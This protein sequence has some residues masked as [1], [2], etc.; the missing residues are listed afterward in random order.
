MS[1][2][3]YIKFPEIHHGGFPCYVIPKYILESGYCS[4]ISDGCVEIGNITGNLVTMCQHV[5]VSE[6]ESLYD[7]IWC[8]D[9]HGYTTQDLLRMYR[10]AY[11][12][13]LQHNEMLSE[14]D[15]DNGWGT[16]SSLHTF[17]GHSIE[18]LKLFDGFPCCVFRC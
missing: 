10:E 17:L 16:V 2:T 6:T 13:V 12:F 9:E 7:A 11:T 8:I 3:L 14:Y 4:C 18:I 5:P 15:A 1:A